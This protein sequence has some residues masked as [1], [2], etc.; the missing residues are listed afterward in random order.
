M[1]FSG[2]GAARTIFVGVR[3]AATGSQ[4]LDTLANSNQI[5]IDTMCRVVMGKPYFVAFNS[6]LDLVEFSNLGWVEFDLSMDKDAV[7]DLIA[8]E[9]DWI[10]SHGGS[11]RVRDLYG[12]CIRKCYNRLR[13][14]KSVE[15]DESYVQLE[16]LYRVRMPGAIREP[17]V[18][19]YR[20]SIKTDFEFG[21]K[22]LF[23][24]LPG[25]GYRGQ[26]Q[27]SGWSNL[28]QNVQIHTAAAWLNIHKAGTLDPTKVIDP[29]LCDCFPCFPL[30]CAFVFAFPPVQPSSFTINTC[31]C[32]RCSF[33]TGP[34]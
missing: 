6:H 26:F 31:R 17:L 14:G 2:K 34:T 8:E 22:P 11:E 16:E 27:E 29:L 15:P 33:G 25:E 19:M 1:S 23:H 3:E 4:K 10:T 13:S 12:E 5:D 21:D 24:S 18:L 30:N 9:E 32:Q 20:Y 28:P 7:E